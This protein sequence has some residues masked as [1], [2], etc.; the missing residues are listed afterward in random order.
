MRTFEEILKQFP[1]RYASQIVIV[2]R[3]TWW[4]MLQ[5]GRLIGGLAR[6]SHYEMMGIGP[7]SKID[8]W[9]KKEFCTQNNV[10]R[11]SVTRRGS[12]EECAT[13]EV[14]VEWFDEMVLT[15]E[16]VSGLGTLAK[17]MNDAEISW[18][19]VAKDPITG[20]YARTSGSGTIV[21]LRR[22]LDDI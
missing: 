21:E 15:E 22:F 1:P 6:V 3:M 9:V 16:Q 13:S 10:L 20:E 11:V 12:D 8:H 4:F 2:D 5:D 17:S 19:R 14:N 18:E 7:G